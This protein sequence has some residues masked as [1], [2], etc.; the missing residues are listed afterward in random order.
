MKEYVVKNKVKLLVAGAVTTAVLAA[1]AVCTCAASG[2]CFSCLLKSI[3][4]F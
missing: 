3:F 1:A 4:A 2:V